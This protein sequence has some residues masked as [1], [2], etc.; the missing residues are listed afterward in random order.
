MKLSGRRRNEEQRRSVHFSS[1]PNDPLVFL[2][3][4]FGSPESVIMGLVAAILDP[5]DGHFRF[6]MS[7]LLDPNFG[8][9]GSFGWPF[10]VLKSAV[11]GANIGH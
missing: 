7:A 3:S 2:G 4:H 9:F 10:W 1:R 5:V 6:L 11:L 8:H